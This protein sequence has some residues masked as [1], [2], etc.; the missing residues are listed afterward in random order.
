MVIKY[1]LS[2]LFVKLI[3]G[4]DATMVHIPLI[5]HLT[6][7]TIGRV[8]YSIGV[9]IAIILAI[10]F[11]LLF[12]STIR[13]FPYYKFIS[14]ALIFLLAITIQFDL[15]I[16]KPKEQIEKKLRKVKRISVK[17]ILKIM[18]IGFIAAFATVIDDIIA[19]SSLFLGHFST[20]FY[21]ILGILTATILELLMMMFFAKSIQRIK[22]KKEITVVGLIILGILILFE[23]L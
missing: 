7:R 5:A 15:L 10:I 19:Y 18:S 2:G 3:T 20:F 14:V 11:S 13:V 9:L 4:V 6:K 1:F 17:R 12:A 23:V 21:V 16:H 22:W 8:I